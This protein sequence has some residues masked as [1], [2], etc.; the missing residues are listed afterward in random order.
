M[1]I[2]A[3]H[4][5]IGVAMGVYLVRM[6]FLTHNASPLTPVEIIAV[7]ATVLLFIGLVA[8]GGFLSSEK[9]MPI[10]VTAIHKVLPYLTVIS[11]GAL[12]YLL[13]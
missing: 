9:P 12:V 2:Q 4:K 3:I 7:V 6:V 11:T 1:L 10:F 5:L 8:T 13:L